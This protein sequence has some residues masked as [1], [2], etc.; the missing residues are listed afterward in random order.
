MLLSLMVVD[1]WTCCVFRCLPS[2]FLSPPLSSCKRSET[3]KFGHVT[4]FW[5]GNRSGKLDDQLET[6]HEVPSDN[7]PF[8]EKP[9]MKAK[10]IAEAAR[11]ALLSG[12]YDYVRI[13]LANGDMVGHTGIFP[14]VLEACEA[15]DKAVKV[16]SSRGRGE[17]AHRVGTVA[18]RGAG[19]VHSKWRHSL[20]VVEELGWSQEV[21]YSSPE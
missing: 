10:E 17:G 13:N 7:C 19:E 16:S 8:N 21:D 6:Y 5:N 12:K 15:V 4:F 18:W 2:A 11:E 3:Q 9:L 1:D 20:G 14:A